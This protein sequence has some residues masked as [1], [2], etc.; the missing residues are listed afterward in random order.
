MDVSAY[1]ISGVQW[2]GWAPPSG[3]FLDLYLSKAALIPRYAYME[4]KRRAASRKYGPKTSCK[5]NYEEMPEPSRE[6]VA[7]ALRSYPKRASYFGPKE[8]FA[9]TLALVV[10]LPT[11]VQEWIILR[12]GTTL[13]DRIVR[14]RKSALP[15]RS[16]KSHSHRI[17]M[18]VVAIAMVVGLRGLVNLLSKHTR[19]DGGAR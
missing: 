1:D 3:S 12:A 5:M 6:E 8:Q 14:G 15:D 17:S 11:L 9:A 18:V 7:R 19:A 13:Y 4:A 16:G 2:S 10:P